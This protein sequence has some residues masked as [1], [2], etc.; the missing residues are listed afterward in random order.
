MEPYYRSKAKGYSREK[1]KKTWRMSIAN[2]F[3]YSQNVTKDINRLSTLD[4]QRVV[5]GCR[6]RIVAREVI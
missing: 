1:S 5:E 3:W 6:D 4:I 2:V